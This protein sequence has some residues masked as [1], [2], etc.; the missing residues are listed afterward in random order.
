MVLPA[1]LGK[2]LE[3]GITAVS[4]QAHQA[5]LPDTM[6]VLPDTV[7]DRLAGCFHIAA[8]IVV[9]VGAGVERSIEF[10]RRFIRH[11]KRLLDVFG[12][13]YRRRRLLGSAGSHHSA[14]YF[15]ES[16]QVGKLPVRLFNV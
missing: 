2:E 9:R 10:I 12:Y 11:L 3:A 14:R 8:H 15:H 1:S 4:R 7:S 16:K 13:H 6:L 5:E